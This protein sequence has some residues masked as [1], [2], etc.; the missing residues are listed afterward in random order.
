MLE[1]KKSYG[2]TFF[3]PN[4]ARW[5]EDWVDE[6]GQEVP[7]LKHLKQNIGEML[8]KALAAIEDENDALHGVLKHNIDFNAGKG[9][10]NK[11]RISD[12][13]WKDLL[14]H[15]NDPRRPLTPRQKFAPASQPLATGRLPQT[16]HSAENPS[17]NE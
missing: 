4:R 16:T 1:D 8:N 6:N 2:E 13:R 17:A 10:D 3:V 15:F 5:N 7:P 9:K 14:D 11:A 12:Q